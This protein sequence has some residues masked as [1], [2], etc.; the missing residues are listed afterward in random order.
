MTCEHPRD[1]AKSLISCEYYTK[2][3]KNLWELQSRSTNALNF[4][5]ISKGSWVWSIEGNFQKQDKCDSQMES[6]MLSSTSPNS[7]NSE[8]ECYFSQSG[9]T[10][11][12]LVRSSTSHWR[13]VTLPQPIHILL[14]WFLLLPIPCAYKSFSF[15]TVS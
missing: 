6:L 11:P 3:S 13:E 8:M 5:H 10:W 7:D 4:D 14:V 9:I 15:C 2:I 1:S 12:A